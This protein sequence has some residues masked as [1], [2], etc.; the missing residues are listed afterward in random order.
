MSDFDENNYNIIKE[1]DDIK[2]KQDNW[3][4]AFGMQAVDDLKPSKY[5]IELARENI[6][7]K[8]SYE[9]VKED[10]EK[11][12]QNSKNIN[13]DEKQADEVSVRIV[14]I[15]NDKA[16]TF[17]YLSLK[18]YHKRLFE[19]VEIGINPKYIG[20]F[21]DYNITKKEP[22]LNGET[23][24]YADFSMIE[25][26]LKYDFEEELSQQY[27]KMSEEE[28]I[29]R[30]VKFASNI[31]QVHPFGEGNTRTTAVFIQKY[32]ISKGFPVNNVLFKDNSKFF[33]NA[34]VKANYSN[35]PKGIEEDKT[36]LKM[37]FENLLLGKHNKLYL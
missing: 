25:E 13:Y 12:Y 7:G 36:Y 27:T 26:T 30:L 35:I 22:I 24:Q 32:L 4:I 33:R 21:R 18:Q 9:K 20:A 15:L 2:Q 19:G 37:F 17:N 1:S 28:T 5:M 29:N 14:K 23:V 31:W 10:I 6:Y 3:G 11:Y 16:F 34:L 8:K